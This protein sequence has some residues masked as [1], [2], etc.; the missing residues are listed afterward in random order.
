MIIQ[1]NTDNNIEGRQQMAAHYESVLADALS[2]FSSQIT[3]LEVHMSDEN[4]D[5]KGTDDKRCMLEARVEGLQ[6]IAVTAQSGTLHEAVSA[7]VSKLK[8]ALDSAIGKLKQY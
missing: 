8:H 7:A 2:R 4:S 1:I 6:P 5:K 3:R